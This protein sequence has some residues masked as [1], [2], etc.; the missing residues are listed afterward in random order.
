MGVKC[1]YG[2]KKGFAV[3]CKILKKK[4]SPLK[5]PCM[6]D[7][8][9]CP[10]YREAQSALESKI[11]HEPEAVEE[12]LE[13]RLPREERRVV[14]EEHKLPASTNFKPPELATDCRE[15]VYY[16]SLTGYCMK[17]R[18]KVSDPRRPPCKG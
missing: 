2:E 12:V 8:T 6:G 4:V 10:H 17:L 11:T 9:H 16:S 18:V 7:Y 14:V 15:C 5:Y 1:P 13:S 3:Y